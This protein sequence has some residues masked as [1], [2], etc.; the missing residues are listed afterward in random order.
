MAYI[1][2]IMNL[3][4]V[5]GPKCHNNRRPA[6]LMQTWPTEK[7]DS[8]SNSQPIIRMFTAIFIVR[9]RHKRFAVILANMREIHELSNFGI[10]GCAY[11]TS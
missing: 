1:M 9:Q 3:N 7:H 4:T 5:L 6:S 11:T 8:A 10:I 2:E